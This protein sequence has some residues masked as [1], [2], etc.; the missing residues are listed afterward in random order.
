M[1]NLHG[2]CLTFINYSIDERVNLPSFIT[3][4]FCKKCSCLSVPGITL[5]SRLKQINKKKKNNKNKKVKNELVSVCLYCEEVV[6]K[7]DGIEKKKEIKQKE[8]IIEEK[9]QATSNITSSSSTSNSTTKI[10]AT[11]A[12]KQAAIK[13]K[14]SSTPT[15]NTLAKKASTF[16]QNFTSAPK[17]SFNM[18]PSTTPS[19]STLSSNIFNN[20][21][22]KRKSSSQ[23]SP[24]FISLSAF[25]KKIN[26]RK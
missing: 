13:G 25:S 23:D 10:S 7:F 8:E 5:S 6:D 14:I 4:Q 22:N 2:L 18:K 19:T 26:T 17:F 1:S 15:S 20:N 12:Q 24:D 21:N 11:Q 3:N 16:G 9:K